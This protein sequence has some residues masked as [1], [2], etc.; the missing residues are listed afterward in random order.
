MSQDK[1]HPTLCSTGRHG[2]W[3]YCS[4]GWS[5]KTYG[6]TTGAHLAFGRH[7]VSGEHISRVG[8]PEANR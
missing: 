8:L 3:A 6:T 1:H 2:C 7:L 4:C 5:S